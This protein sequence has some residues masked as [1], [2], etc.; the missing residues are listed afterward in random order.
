V[1]EVFMVIPQGYAQSCGIDYEEIFSLVAK[2]N[3]DGLAFTVR[4]V[5]AFWRR[6]QLLEDVQ[7]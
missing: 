5:Q 4:T 6:K 1:E 7:L 3:I 2:M